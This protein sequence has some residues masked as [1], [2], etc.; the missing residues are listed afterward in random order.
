M[1]PFPW[2]RE[3]LSRLLANRDRLPHAVLVHGPTGIGKVDFARA[4]G[5]A[6]LCED[7]RPAGACGTCPSCHWYSQGNHPDFREILPEAAAEE[8]VG[9]AETPGARPEKA[10]SLVIKIDQ[11][12]AVG[13][14]IALTTHRAGHR[15]LLLH[16]AEALQPASANALLKTLEEPPPSTLIVLVSDRPARLLP[17]LLSRCRRLPLRTPPRAEALAWLREQGVER[18]EAALDAAGGAPL[19]ARDLA[20]SQ[21]ADLRR[22]LVAELAKPGGADA[23]LFAGS[24]DRANLERAIWWMQTWVHDLVRARLAGEVRHHGEHAGALQA[25][26]RGADLPALLDLDRELAEARRLASHPLNPRLLTEHLLL[27]YNRAISGTPR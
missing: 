27:A 4:L 6:V 15:V 11:V 22:R 24:V 18:P 3:A 1:K 7:P 10:K 2:H 13:D 21:E 14:F 16:P 25:R 5:A 23:L 8:E 26:A 19:L 12:R 9:E 17:T 20:E